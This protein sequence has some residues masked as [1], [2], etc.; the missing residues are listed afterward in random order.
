[1][2]PEWYYN[3]YG[4]P[5]P[6]S[7]NFECMKRWVLFQQKAYQKPD[8][9]LDYT[10]YGDW[11]DGSW[12]KGASDKRTT[13]RPLM[14]TAYYFNNCRIV[15]RAA[16]LLGNAEEAK[17]FGDLADKV[18]AGSTRGSSTRRRTRMRARPRART[19]SRWPSAWS[20]KNAGP[21]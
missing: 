4:D 20:P 5:R 17:R 6:L 15:A 16:R 12:I 14:A 21:R 13:S 8:Y 19:S 3:F 11:V 10:N 1:M 9:T 7:D 18:R 2:I